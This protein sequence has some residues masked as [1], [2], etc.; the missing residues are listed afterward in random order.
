MKIVCASSVLLGVEAFS[1]LGTVLT[2]PDEA[3]STNVLTDV[4]AL[5]VRSKTTVDENLL[6]DTP[7][8]FVGTATAGIDH[9]DVPYLEDRGIAW[10]C[11]AG[12]NACSVAEY[13]VA[14]TLNMV[15]AH[16]LLLD[17]LAIG[18]IGVGHVGREVSR[19]CT[20]MGLRVLLND[21]PRTMVENDPALIPLDELLEEADI[22]TLHVP[23]E[24]R[25]HFATRHLVDHRFFEKVRSGVLFVNASRGEVVDSDAL[26]TA[27]D[28]GTVR[29]AA[30]DVWEHEP[31]IRL[32]V[33]DRVDLGTAH[34]AGHSHEGKLKGT[35]MLYEDACQFFEV[36]GTF[37][38]A[39]HVPDLECPRIELDA[40]GCLDQDVLWNAV[41]IAY[42]LQEDDRR[43][44][45]GAVPDARARGGYF[46]GL[47]RNYGVRREFPAYEVSLKN[48]S[49][50]QSEKLTGLGFQVI[51]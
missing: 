45:E 37:N 32:D 27:L 40:R 6:K 34:I 7:V 39:H 19:K 51:G 29:A 46:A 22:I 47:R 11:A 30:L 21:P 4:D 44:R 14:A 43:L 9:M 13:A 3:I 16:G 33:L 12:S 41:R 25:G 26:L 17:E 49:A 50:K 2:V 10:S 38:P 23:L 24:D 28:S 18:I 8:A 15:L 42:D 36:P 20:S 35:L 1:T 48:G 5:I 31:E